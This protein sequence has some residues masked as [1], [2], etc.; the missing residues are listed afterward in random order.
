MR[1]ASAA[2]IE[3][4]FSRHL[5]P[6]ALSSLR[7][8]VTDKPVVVIAGD[9]LTGKSTVAKRIVAN[10][11]ECLF[12]SSGASFRAEAEQRGLTVAE[13]SKQLHG[14]PTIDLAVDHSVCQ[15]IGGGTYKERRAVVE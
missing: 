13:L 3:A 4:A 6:N 7:A 5:G 2:G 9:Q 1:R 15:V 8:N 11:A 12:W 10:H 14:D